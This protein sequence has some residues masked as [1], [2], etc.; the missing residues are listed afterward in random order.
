MQLYAPAH[1]IARSCECSIRNADNQV[2]HIG[3]SDPLHR[4]GGAQPHFTRVERGPF[5]RGTPG[6]ELHGAGAEQHAESILLVDLKV[7]LFYRPTDFGCYPHFSLTSFRALD[8][9]AIRRNTDDSARCLY[10]DTFPAIA[11]A[12]T[13]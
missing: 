5:Q 11:L 1:S 10:S 2:L 8:A 4:R 3:G 7:G 12:T 13:N 9:L 6:A